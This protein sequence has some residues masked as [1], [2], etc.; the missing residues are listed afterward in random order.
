MGWLIG[1]LILVA[2]FVLL[3]FSRHIAA[4]LA[5]MVVWLS[6]G[7]GGAWF[8]SEARR[9]G[10]D[11]ETAHTYPLASA[12]GTHRI[13]L[14]PLSQGSMKGVLRGG[15][16]SLER[17][18]LAKAG[19]SFTDPRIPATWFEA[20]E[21]DP[22]GPGETLLFYTA[23]TGS[24]VPPAVLEYRVDESRQTW[25]QGRV[26]A[27]G[28]DATA[29]H[30]LRDHA[31]AFLNFF[32]VALLL[33]GGVWLIVQVVQTATRGKEKRLRPGRDGGVPLS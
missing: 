17:S 22:A 19:W 29:R 24:D 3:R 20:S 28:H 2:P 26:L 25:F 9:A 33:W 30:M 5:L 18:E 21:H 4:R 23:W 13:A 11:L 10:K 14:T 1:L 31:M 8:L 6:C 32:G 7:G 15:A 16:G 12:P 27:I